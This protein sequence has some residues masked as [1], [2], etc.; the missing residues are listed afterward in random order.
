[1]PLRSPR[2]GPAPSPGSPQ[3][4]WGP[5][6]SPGNPT[7]ELRPASSPE[8]GS[9]QPS[10]R[11]RREFGRVPRQGPG[12][13]PSGRRPARLR[14]VWRR[15]GFLLVGARGSGGSVTRP[16][17]HD[18]RTLP[19]Q[20]AWIRQR[21]GFLFAAGRSSGGFR[22]KAQGTRPA[23]A[24]R[25]GCVGFGG[26][27][28]S[29]VWVAGVRVGLG[30]SPGRRDERTS[31]R[32]I[33]WV[34]EGVGFFGLGGWGSGGFGAK[35]RRPDERTPPRRIAW[36]RE[37]LASSGWV[38][39][40]RVRFGGKAPETRPGAL[41]PTTVAPRAGNLLAE[42]RGWVFGS[43]AADLAGTGPPGPGP[44]PGG[45]NGPAPDEPGKSRSRSR[46]RS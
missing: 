24:A 32:R 34:R 30:R 17:K 33:V 43:C 2:T 28:A 12:D 8:F 27:L 38:A 11:G 7:T 4:G 25:P 16:R 21:A 36:N 23:G 46:S 39:G 29:S 14:G 22:D 42:R 35:P 44:V 40:V 15:A 20:L 6:Q 31:R 3:L 19:R 37:G 45:S 26:G 9:G 18:Q 5:G 1:M 13:P 41:S 10:S